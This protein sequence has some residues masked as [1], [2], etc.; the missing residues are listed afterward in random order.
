MKNKNFEEVI[1]S[2]QLP[3]KVEQMFKR[4]YKTS[5]EIATCFK[6][7]IGVESL[8]DQ[9]REA[10]RYKSD[11]IIGKHLRVILFGIKQAGYLKLDDVVCLSF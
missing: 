11:Y 1:A 10:G 9:I 2:M 5:D 8:I 6:S 3:E 7:G 4:K